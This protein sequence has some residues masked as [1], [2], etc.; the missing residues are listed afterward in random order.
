MLSWFNW[1]I[2][3]KLCLT[4][5]YR[6]QEMRA[7]K[8]WIFLKSYIENKN[9]ENHAKNLFLQKSCWMVNSEMQT[10]VYIL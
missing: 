4:Y 9:K 5:K 3:Y 7:W 8:I 10:F 6:K 2:V 1:Y